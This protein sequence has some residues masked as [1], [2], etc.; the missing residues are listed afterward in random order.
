MTL[1]FSVNILYISGTWCL[2]TGGKRGR[3]LGKPKR[4]NGV[5]LFAWQY[6][7]WRPKSA[8]NTFLYHKEASK[9][10]SCYPRY[11]I[12]ETTFEI[13][14]NCRNIFDLQVKPCRYDKINEIKIIEWNPKKENVWHYM[15]VFPLSFSPYRTLRQCYVIGMRWNQ[16]L[17]VRDDKRIH[18]NGIWM[19]FSFGRVT[20]LAFVLK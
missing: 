6:K 12:D 11:I 10:P 5:T 9:E 1:R 3:L 13:P 15:A 19:K 20:H 16:L 4:T 17:K 18:K 2:S 14:I 8:C 7:V